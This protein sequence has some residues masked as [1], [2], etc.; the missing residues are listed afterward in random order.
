MFL[1]AMF[2]DCSATRLGFKQLRHQRELV[3]E[4]VIWITQRRVNINIKRFAQIKPWLFYACAFKTNWLKRSTLFFVKRTAIIF[5]KLTE[6]WFRYHNEQ[7][8][9]K[10]D[11]FYLLNISHFLSW[12]DRYSGWPHYE[13]RNWLFQL[14]CIKNKEQCYVFR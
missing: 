10:N 5:V 11:N 9:S 7:I 3:D 4:E 13:Q 12:F 14:T 6:F 1:T 2:F 8:N